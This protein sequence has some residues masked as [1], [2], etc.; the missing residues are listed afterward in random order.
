VPVEENGDEE[1]KKREEPEINIVID[2]LPERER[3][4]NH[5]IL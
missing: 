1:E 2:H 5:T 3:R 4:L